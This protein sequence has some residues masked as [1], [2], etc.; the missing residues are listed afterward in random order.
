[1]Q[2]TVSP[3]AD[4]RSR[5]ADKRAEL[6]ERSDKMAYY[7]AQAEQRA[8]AAAGGD[9]KMLG[10]NAEARA[11]ALTIAL[12]QDR[13]YTR[14]YQERQQTEKEVNDLQTAIDSILDARR[15]EEWSIRGRLVGALTGRGLDHPG[16]GTGS[17][18]VM[19]E[20]G[21]Q[22]ALAHAQAERDLDDLWP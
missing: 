16:L 19:T 12:W 10:A 21:T 5:I 17:T 2:Y 13:E 8:I 11:R 7:R 6:Q 15:A 22:Q 9:E 3:L 20:A 4:L 14:A 1:M 18:D